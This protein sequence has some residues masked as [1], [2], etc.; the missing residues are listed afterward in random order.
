MIPGVKKRKETKVI[1]ASEWAVDVLLRRCSRRPPDDVAW[2]E[3][4][5]RYDNTIR[6]NVQRTFN[7]KARSESDRRQQFRDDETEDLTQ[8]VYIRLVEGHCRALKR[9]E[10]EYTNSIYQYLAMIA[11]NVVRDHFRETKAQK[12]PK[13]SHSLEQLLESGD[14]VL[15]GEAVVGDESVG[16]PTLEDIE[17]ALRRSVS[18]KHRDRD[19]LIFRLHYFDGL[20]SDE[21]IKVMQLD[22]TSIGVNSILSRTMKKMRSSL[23]PGR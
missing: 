22:I 21:I 3:F 23:F 11:V 12:R 18:W 13:I 6:A 15:R 17:N 9:F 10:G 4:V 1:P 16:R 19:M 2:A 8:L 5:R 14:G 20:S 7:R